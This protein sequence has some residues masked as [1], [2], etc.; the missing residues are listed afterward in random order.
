M[1]DKKKASNDTGL[2]LDEDFIFLCLAGMKERDV[3][4]I[5]MIYSQSLSSDIPV[6][7]WK[8]RF[9][10]PICNVGDWLRIDEF[11]ATSLLQATHNQCRMQAPPE[12]SEAIYTLHTTSSPCNLEKT[13][14]SST[15]NIFHMSTSFVL[16]SV[17]LH[18]KLADAKRRRPLLLPLILPPGDNS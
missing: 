13:A 6:G 4:K 3:I 14:A 10:R 16:G 7:S 8:V 17:K 11:L 1:K 9:V 12:S 2:K 5:E 18:A 15:F